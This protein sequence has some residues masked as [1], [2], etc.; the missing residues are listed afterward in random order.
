VNFIL[1]LIALR[2]RQRP[3]LFQGLFT[4]QSSVN[5]VLSH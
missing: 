2:P 1:C 3:G 4:S 5:K